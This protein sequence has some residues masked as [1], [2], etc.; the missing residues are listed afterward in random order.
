MALHGLEVEAAN[1]VI[2]Y[3]AIDRGLV[4]RDRLLDM[5]EGEKPRLL[6]M[7]AGPLIVHYEQIPGINCIINHRRITLS[8]GG[9]IEPGQ[10]NLSRMAVTA[11]EAVRGARMVAYGFN[12]R[13]MGAVEGVSDVG[14]FLR[15]SF[16]R[17][18]EQLATAA[19]GPVSS[20]S[21]AFKYSV[22]DIQYRLGL[23]SD[24]SDETLFRAQLNVHHA[25]DTL[26]AEDQLSRE[27]RQAFQY[28]GDL[29]ERVLST[30]TAS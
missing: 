14:L 26:P 4:S 22:G 11:S 5:I 3:D 6:D 29:L 27:L 12:F 25:T 24:E 13:I 15:D 30:G 21:L 17:E 10:G 8:Q 20:L 7:S 2:T 1:I 28:S 16:L 23:D 9:R 19:G 18:P